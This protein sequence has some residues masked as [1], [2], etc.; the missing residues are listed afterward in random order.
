MAPADQ[1]LHRL[2]TNDPVKTAQFVDK[3]AL[4]PKTVVAD[5]VS[6]QFLTRL[7]DNVHHQPIR[8]SNKIRSLEQEVGRIGH[9]Q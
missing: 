9:F 7:A 2:L 6:K 8:F 4:Q 3:Q 1:S 5:P